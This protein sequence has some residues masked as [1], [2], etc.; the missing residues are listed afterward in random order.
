MIGTILLALFLYLR[1]SSAVEQ[2]QLEM[3][4]RAQSERDRLEVE[5]GLRT[6]QLTELTH[7]V[8]TLND[9]ITLGR[10]IIEDLRPSS[11]GNLGLVAAL[12]ILL[13]EFAQQT[14]VEVDCALEPV[15]L[16]ANSELVIYRLVQE[17]VPNITK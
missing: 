15:D 4:R 13:G 11:L 9:S 12:E 3:S 6:A 17:A 14:G 16:D 1:Q 2:Y 5:V 7:L 8:S 10:R